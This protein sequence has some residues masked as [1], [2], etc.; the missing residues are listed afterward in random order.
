MPGSVTSPA[1][2]RSYPN[3]GTA[4]LFPQYAPYTDPVTVLVCGGSNFG[5]ALDNCVSIQPEVANATWV[6]ERMVRT[7]LCFTLIFHLSQ[8]CFSAAIEA[9]NAL[10]RKYPIIFS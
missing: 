10:Y 5:V 1:A 8:S 6:L 9:C 2:G 3:E 7:S 4:V